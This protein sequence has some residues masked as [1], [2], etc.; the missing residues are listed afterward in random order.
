M[1]AWAGTVPFQSWQAGQRISPLPFPALTAVSG[2][3]VYSA[4]NVPSGVI[5]DFTSRT[6]YGVPEAE[7]DG[8]ITL[9]VADDDNTADIEI[10]YEIAAR[11]V[12]IIVPP[13]PD[14][15]FHLGQAVDYGFPQ[16]VGGSGNYTTRLEYRP[17]PPWDDLPV[18]VSTLPDGLS[19]DAAT[20]RLT[21]TL[22]DSLANQGQSLA[23]VTLTNA[24][25][26]AADET[27]T[28]F[29]TTDTR[30]GQ[31]ASI[32][33]PS[34]NYPPLT[35]QV[36]NFVTLGTR[37]GTFF[38][39][40][41]PALDEQATALP[42]NP[43]AFIVRPSDQAVLASF[44]IAVASRPV[45]TTASMFWASD[46]LFTE[47]DDFYIEIATSERSMFDFVVTDDDT[48]Q[49]VR[50]PFTIV[51]CIFRSRRPGRAYAC[52]FIRRGNNRFRYA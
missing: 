50:V 19:Y 49:V 52:F 5:V 43:S 15:T 39:R 31:S 13:I 17:I 16:P 32:L 46:F 48:G 35:G 9:S 23:Q 7:G 22:A 18:R 42:N 47:G 20:R 10:V 12:P 37:N 40:Y 27:Q 29:I 38:L 30:S 6:I 36:Y 2:G 45:V 14:L 11:Q 4:A 34:F 33:G 1:V 44:P 21:G 25:V 51:A 41:D 8:T 24:Q 26:S 3:L 28:G